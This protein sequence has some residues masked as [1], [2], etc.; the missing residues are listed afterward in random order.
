V[1]RA[2]SPIGCY[3]IA[4]AYRTE[5]ADAASAVGGVAALVR[6]VTPFSLYTPHTGM[7]GYSG[8]VP[9]IPVA[10]I[11]IEDAELMARFQARGTPITVT[12]HMDAQNLPWVPSA[13]VVAEVTG[14]TWPDEVVLVSGHLDSWDVGQGA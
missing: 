5:G 14:S 3:G 8:A 12:L 9:K 4:V 1:L 6:S 11:T 7:Q 10:C 13:N 2:V